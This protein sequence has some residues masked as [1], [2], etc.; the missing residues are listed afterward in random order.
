MVEELPDYENILDHHQRRLEAQRA[1]TPGTVE[2]AQTVELP[3]FLHPIRRV[4]AIQAFAGELTTHRSIVR[5][6]FSRMQLAH[7]AEIMGGTAPVERFLEA[8]GRL[9]ERIK[10]LNQNLPGS[11]S[12]EERK[13]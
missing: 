2:W 6:T 12:P 11:I 5:M 13:Q 4:Q 8:T 1:R 3:S 10:M 9:D 7:V